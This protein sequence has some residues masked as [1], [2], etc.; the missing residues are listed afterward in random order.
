[1]KRKD[2]PGNTSIVVL[3]GNKMKMVDIGTLLDPQIQMKSPS[4][5]DVGK[6]AKQFSLKTIH[7]AVNKSE[8]NEVSL[9]FYQCVVDAVRDYHS[10][11]LKGVKINNQTIAHPPMVLVYENNINIPQEALLGVFKQCNAADNPYNIFNKQRLIM[12]TSL[13]P[14]C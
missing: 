14:I 2:E 4:K 1:M 13:L 3:K 12:Q 10:T 6:W 8:S 7:T 9:E 5:D 11:V